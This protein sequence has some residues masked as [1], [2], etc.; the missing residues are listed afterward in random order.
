[1]VLIMKNARG[2][3]EFPGGQIEEGEDIIQGLQREI[4]EETGVQVKVGKLVGVYSNLSQPTI[5]NFNF[6]CEWISG[7]IRTSDESLEVAWFSR[8]EVL[9]KITLPPIHDRMRD[10]LEFEG[11]VVYRAYSTD[12]YEVSVER[13]M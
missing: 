1:M 5:V 3:W 11:E 12:P 7:D 2:E 10:M 6:L 13:T 4:V 9:E 8:D